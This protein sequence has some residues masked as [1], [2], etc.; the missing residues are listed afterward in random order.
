MIWYLI[1]YVFLPSSLASLA[2]L[3]YICVANFIK[4]KAWHKVWES[5]RPSCKRHLYRAWLPTWYLDTTSLLLLPLLSPL[6]LPHF[7]FFDTK[8]QLKPV[9]KARYFQARVPF[10]FASYLQNPMMLMVGLTMLLSF[11]MPKLMAN[12]GM[13]FLFFLLLFPSKNSSFLIKTST[14]LF[15]LQS[16]KI[17]P[18]ALKEMQGAPNPNAPTPVQGV[19][20]WT[21]PLIDNKKH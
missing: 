14:Y 7:L 18:E 8:L 15:F 5:T 4:D 19:P 13:L 9:D 16:K 17:D 6:P 10:N 2:S 20:V 12:M 1:L 21:P 11:V 3:S